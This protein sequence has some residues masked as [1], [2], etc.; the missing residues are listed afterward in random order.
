MV[1]SSSSRVLQAPM[2]CLCSIQGMAHGFCD[3]LVLLGGT[4][5]GPGLDPGAGQDVVAGLAV[6]NLLIFWKA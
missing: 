1:I 3:L 6:E 4:G 2:S 5:M